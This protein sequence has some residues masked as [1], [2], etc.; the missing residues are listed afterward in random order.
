MQL[1]RS[2]AF[3]RRPRFVCIL[4]M[5]VLDIPADVAL[6][7]GPQLFG[8]LFNYGLFGILT[9][10]VYFYHLAF[11]TDPTRLKVL[12]YTL[13]IVECIQVIL[14]SHDAYKVLGEGWGDID[15]LTKVHY[16]WIDSQMITGIVSAIVQC[17]F[18]WRIYVLSTSAT[19][20]AFISFVALTQ[21]CAAIVSGVRSHMLDDNSRLQEE[22]LPSS[23]VWLVG[24]ATCDI[25][26][27]GCMLYFLMRGRDR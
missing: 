5:P 8:H 16:Q 4:S 9:I 12:I 18:S 7:A 15:A 20:A 26:I 13:Y 14:A 10:Q 21:G 23:I 6:L 11:P 17:Y 1:P 27:A 25:L 22:T 24:S 3:L 19:L 2:F